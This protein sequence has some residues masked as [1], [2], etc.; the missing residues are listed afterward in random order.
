MHL[1]LSLGWGGGGAVTTQ[2]NQKGGRRLGEGGGEESLREPGQGLQDTAVNG[3]QRLS[4]G[5]VTR[6]ARPEPSWGHWMNC[7]PHGPTKGHGIPGVWV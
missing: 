1:L 5:L 7:V 4:V 3:G 2:V 6:M